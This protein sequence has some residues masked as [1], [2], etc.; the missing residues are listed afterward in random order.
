MS[1]R[2]PTAGGPAV[3]RVLMALLA[4]LATV[5]TV[6]LAAGCGGGVAQA[7]AF[8]PGRVLVLG[9]EFSALLDDGRRWGVNGVDAG[10]GRLDCSAQPLWVQ[11]VAGSFGFAF[12]ACNTSS[13]NQEPRALMLARPQALVASLSEQ[14]EALGT[15]GSARDRDL[16]LV[17]AGANDV[18]QMYADFPTRS[19]AA[20]MAELRNRADQLAAVV[21][22]LVARGARVVVV[23]LPDLGMSPYA[24]AER[25]AF[26]DSGVD[27]AALI[28]RMSTTFN[29]RLG[30]K[31]L[32][33]GRYVGLVQMDQR[34]QAIAR[35][36]GNFG[37]ADI[38]TQ[39]CSVPPPQCTTL[40]LQPGVDAA[41]HLWAD[42]RFYAP[43]GQSQ[44]AT[45]ALDI[46]RRNPF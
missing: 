46:I 44:L 1:G 30:V 31:L 20:L 2:K 38:S 16:A 39:A 15:L 24:R 11:S 40:T 19:E 34:S 28:T 45:L 41:S 10:T 37:F 3:A 36:P 6:V 33:D 14:L 27:R 29:E 18:W 22:R 32:L 4:A 26:A 7:E 5:A 21:D 25:D 43:G 23:N 17:M 9:D 13:P 42:A 8:V 12:E 35:S